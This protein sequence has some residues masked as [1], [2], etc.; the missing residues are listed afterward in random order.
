MTDGGHDARRG[1]VLIGDLVQRV[2]A[3]VAEHGATYEEYRAA[4]QWL[5]E[6]G[7]AGEWPL[8]LDVFV[9]SA[10]EE[11]AYAARPGSPGAIEGPYYLPDA[12]L[13]QPPF[14]LPCRDDEPGEALVLSGRVT[15]AGGGPL[16][17]ALLDVW[18]A[19][20]EGRYSG[21][22]S[23]V[24][25]GNLR[26]RVTAGDDGRYEVRTV[27][28][29]PYTIPHDGPTGRLI[30]AAGWHPWRPAHIHLKVSADGHELLTTQLTLADSEW[31]DDDVARAVK[32]PLIVR[33]QRRDGVLRIE[34]DF[35]LADLGSEA[36][37]PSRTA[38]AVAVAAPAPGRPTA[39]AAPGEP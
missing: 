5:I 27:R 29:A 30:A 14:R 15:S 28:P 26:G 36:V 1:A 11:R 23:E 2:R 24:P 8:F 31:V 19:D 6:V 20:A 32:E 25:D 12:P 4:K 35:V 38:G 18:Q 7:E 10:V 21:F 13:L 9:E 16:A 39:V 34:H 33:P 22:S 3:F 17:G 37:A